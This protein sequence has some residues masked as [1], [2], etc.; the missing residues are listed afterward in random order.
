VVGGPVAG[1][2][3]DKP[4]GDERAGGKEKSE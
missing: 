2:T 1:S 3:V 4:R